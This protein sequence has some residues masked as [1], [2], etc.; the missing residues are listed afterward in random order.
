[1]FCVLII[2]SFNGLYNLYSQSTSPRKNVCLLL[3]TVVVQ[4]G[5]KKK[6][7]HG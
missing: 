4:L 7:V 2:V 6:T 1:M 3:T 5:N